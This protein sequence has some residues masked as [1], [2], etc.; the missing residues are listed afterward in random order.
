[1]SGHRLLLL[2]AALALLLGQVTGG[3]PAEPRAAEVERLVRQLGSDIFQEREAA[4]KALEEIGVP[5]LQALQRATTDKDPEVRRR[6][7]GLVE[8]V[9]TR[10]AARA[11]AAVRRLE[12]SLLAGDGPGGPQVWVMF[13]PGVADDA[14]LA[15]LAWLP[16]L[17]V[18][19]LTRS[20][21][22]GPGLA[23]LRQAATL[24][25]LYLADTP[26]TD[27]GLSHLR[28]LPLAVLDLS[29]TGVGDAGMAA[30]GAMDTLTMLFLSDTR[31]TDAGV[32][33][34]AGL[35][36]LQVLN[37]EGTGVTDAGLARLRDLALW[38][39]HVS[40]TKVTAKGVAELQRS[41]PEA[42]ITR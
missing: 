37:L 27:A 7:A 1:M 3:E 12:G 35:R 24:R 39:L 38:H 23:H 13:P 29:G 5:A 9:R 2:A 31:V 4:S 11:A 33:H 6:A 19:G 20:K 21:V 8:A 30:V 22:S 10:M 40:G 18:L 25:R 14:A 16:H 36:K 15:D 41:L 42:D 26:V 32:A 17:A 34:L 28:G